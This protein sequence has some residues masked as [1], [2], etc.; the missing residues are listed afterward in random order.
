MDEF[1]VGDKVKF[2]V[3]LNDNNTKWMYGTISNITPYEEDINED[4][5]EILLEDGNIKYLSIEDFEPM[6]ERDIDE[7]VECLLNI[8][9]EKAEIKNIL[10]NFSENDSLRDVLKEA[11]TKVDDSRKI[12]KMKINPNGT[13]DILEVKK[14]EIE[15]DCGAFDTWY[16]CE[17]GKEYHSL[18]INEINTPDSLRYL[19]KQIGN[20]YVDDL[21]YKF[22]YEIRL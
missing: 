16:I 1:K 2:E 14:V 7:D 4:N 9:N 10:S 8:I 20:V 15:G 11:L 6:F 22:K 5:Y 18:V 12:K 3:C 17:D 19:E 13:N 21:F